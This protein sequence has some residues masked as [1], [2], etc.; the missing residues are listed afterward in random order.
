MRKRTFTLVELL[1]VI[2]II[3]ILTAMIVGAATLASRK[4]SESKTKSLL[5]QMQIALDQFQQDW[6]Y[7]PPQ[8]TAGPLQW[9]EEKFKDTNGK[10]LLDNYPAD[11]DSNDNNAYEDAWGNPFWYQC[12]GTMNEESFDLWSCGRDHAHGVAGVNDNGAG[13]TDD[14]ADA[15]HIDADNSDD[16]T[17]WKRNN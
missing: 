7:F 4:A 11:A 6:G 2:S 14:A 10:L 9:D 1:A 15:Q 5:E 8:A 13:A 16:I 3:A 12:P 17:N